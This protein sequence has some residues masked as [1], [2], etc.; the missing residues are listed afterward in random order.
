MP[1]APKMPPE[2]PVLLNPKVLGVVLPPND[3]CCSDPDV[4]WPPNKLGPEVFGVLWALVEPNKEV[5]GLFPSKL[6][7][8]EPDPVF[9]SLPPPNR[10]PVGLDA[11]GEFELLFPAA[12]PKLKAGLLSDILPCLMAEVSPLVQLGL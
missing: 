4:A 8:E 11:K 1:A 12:P 7:G 9:A 2:F 3:F 6:N 5:C 10:F